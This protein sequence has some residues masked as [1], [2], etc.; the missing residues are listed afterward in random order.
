MKPIP[1]PILCSL[2][3]G[4]GLGQ[5][6]APLATADE[7]RLDAA[8]LIAQATSVNVRLAKDG[9]SVELERGEVSEDEQPRRAGYSYRPNE[10][11][12]HGDV[13]IRKELLIDD[14]RADAAY[15]LVA[16]GSELGATINGRPIPL[17]AAG[18]TGGYWQKY[19]FDKAALREGK[20][21][22]LLAGEGKVWIARDEDFAAG[23]R[24]L[25]RHPN[26]SARGADG[27]RTWSHES[28]D[29]RATSTANTTSAS[30]S[31]AIA[32][33]ALSRCRRST[34]ATLP[35]SRWLPRLNRSR[36]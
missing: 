10:E 26:R 28:S 3:L 25:T 2:A 20:N 14:P 5:V 9:P 1:L 7:L 34:W 16:P 12:L 13:R 4:C 11:R 19:A 18:K 6:A 32:R 27:G 35:E 8:G 23:S 31:T 17:K 36:R 24:M 30:S 33:P 21:E 29:R 15:L 22:I